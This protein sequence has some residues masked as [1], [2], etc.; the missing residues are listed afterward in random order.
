MPTSTEAYPFQRSG[1]KRCPPTCSIYCPCGRNVD[2]FGCPT[3]SCKPSN[4]CTGR[5]PNAFGRPPFV[6]SSIL[7]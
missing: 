5:H 6:K 3:C 1:F 2:Q 4:T 7:Y